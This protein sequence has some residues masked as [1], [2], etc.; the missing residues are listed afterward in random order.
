[1]YLWGCF[2]IGLTFESLESKADCP[3]MCRWCHP[4]YANTTFKKR[5]RQQ[6]GRMKNWPLLCFVSLLELRHWFSLALKLEFTPSISLL[7]RLLNVGWDYTIGSPQSQLASG[8]SWDF[9]A[10]II[11]WVHFLLYINIDIWYG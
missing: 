2:L 3:P 8:K 10:F 11:A 7:P 6:N 4:V 9:L 1:M 5:K